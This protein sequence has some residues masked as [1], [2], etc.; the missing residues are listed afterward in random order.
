MSS[1][2]EPVKVL[3]V[4]LGNICR[5][6]V[7]EG[8]LRDKISEKGL[9]ASVHIDSAGTGAWHVGEQ[10][11]RRMRLTARQFGVSLEDIRARKLADEDL[12]T[13]DHIFAMDRSNYEDICYLD[14]SGAY[15]SRVQLFRTFDPSADSPDVPDPYYGGQDG[16]ERVFEMVDRTC[17][18]ITEYLIEQHS[19]SAIGE[20]GRHK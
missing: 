4:C 1:S 17:D 16:F 7:A 5:S 13:F 10:P 9:V 19:L 20:P 18:A 14:A 12:W 8:V 6:P 11:D 2:T 15:H 3:F